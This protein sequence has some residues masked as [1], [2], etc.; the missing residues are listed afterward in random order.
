MAATD[1]NQLCLECGLCCNGVI[2]ADGQLQCGDDAERLRSLGLALKRKPLSGYSKFRQPCAAFDGCRCGIYSD[3]PKYCRQ[4]E[5]LLLKS[6]QEGTVEMASAQKL[7]RTARRRAAKVNRLLRELGE[8]GEH[9]ALSVRFRRIQK[10]FEQEIPDTNAVHI[11][12]E[13]TLA[14]HGLQLLLCES[15]YPG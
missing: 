8:T 12:G 11:Y 15:F 13:L 7:I 3:R 10:R 4:F 6:V 9:I 14:M 2:F 5:C 1:S